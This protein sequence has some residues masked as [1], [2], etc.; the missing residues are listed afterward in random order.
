MLFCVEIFLVLSSETKKSLYIICILS[1]LFSIISHFSYY[2]AIWLSYFDKWQNLFEKKI[3]NIQNDKSTHYLHTCSGSQKIILQSKTL[4]TF[5]DCKNV[6]TQISW[7]KKMTSLAV[8]TKRIFTSFSG[9]LPAVRMSDNHTESFVYK[10]WCFCCKKV[11]CFW[12]ERF[13]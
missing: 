8:T 3:L 13:L 2:C 10:R 11:K 9:C 4:L 7:D 6:T 1:K 12:N 5:L